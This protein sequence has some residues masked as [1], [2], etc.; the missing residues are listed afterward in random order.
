MPRFIRRN[1]KNACD[2]QKAII[3]NNWTEARTIVKIMSGTCRKQTTAPSFFGQ[4]SEILPIHQACAC[5]SLPLDFLE[6]LILAYPESV[7][8]P[9]TGLNR[10]PLHIAVKSQISKENILYLLHYHPHSAKRKDS[11]GRVPLH[12]ALSN[13]VPLNII[14]EL[15]H[16][17]PESVSAVDNFNWTP[18]HVAANM[19]APREVISMLV[20][21]GPEVI[22]MKTEGGSTPLKLALESSSIDKD[23]IVSILTEGEKKFMS[24]PIFQNLGEAI[25][26]EQENM[27][28]GNHSDKVGD[29]TDYQC[30]IRKQLSYTS[31]VV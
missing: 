3:T 29:S 31:S 28:Y 15:I 1:S 11:L 25:Q 7:M 16:A 20:Q 2:L 26:K 6:A 17:C 12:Y 14:S 27:R 19:C 30:F 4:I 13:L 8:K 18:L 9:E 10:I 23:V 24:T 5:K 22:S 21:A